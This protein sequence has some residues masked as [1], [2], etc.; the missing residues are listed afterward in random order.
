MNRALDDGVVILLL[1]GSVAYAFSALGPRALRRRVRSSLA[2]AAARAPA[3]LHLA[4]LARRLDQAASKE[5]AG[6]CGGCG[7]CA[8]AGEQKNTAAEVRVPIAKIGKR[9]QIIRR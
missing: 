9:R 8:D 2:R 1:L 6:D 4:G 3:L 7:S 5:S